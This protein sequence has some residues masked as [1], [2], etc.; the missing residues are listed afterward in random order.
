MVMILII[1]LLRGKF[2]MDDKMY[3]MWFSMAA[4]LISVGAYTAN[5]QA[6]K[7]AAEMA[8]RLPVEDD[9]SERK[10]LIDKK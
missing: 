1:S 7:V 10:P 2:Q 8:Q 9:G 5:K 4:I 3:A 6:E